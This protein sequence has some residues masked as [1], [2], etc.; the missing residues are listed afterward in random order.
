MGFYICEHILR[1]GEICNRG[2]YRKEGCKLH[3]KSPE[4]QPCKECGKLTSSSYGYCDTHADKYRKRIYYNK[5]KLAQM[6]Q[7]PAVIE[8]KIVEEKKK[9][10]YIENCNQEN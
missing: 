9:L 10:G 2:S 1:N 3:Y 4:Q 5:K 6:E 7:N 8:R